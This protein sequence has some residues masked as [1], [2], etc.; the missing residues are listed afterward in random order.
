MGRKRQQI[1]AI[2]HLPESEAAVMQFS[3]KICEFYSVQVEKKL[4]SLDITK[5]EKLAIISSLMND[6]T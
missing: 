5:Q 4:H 1:T 3:K 2:L 6:L